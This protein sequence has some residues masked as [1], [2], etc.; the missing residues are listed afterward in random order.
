MSQMLLTFLSYQGLLYSL[1]TPKTVALVLLNLGQ[2][3]R[4]HLS[5]HS[6]VLLSMMGCLLWCCVKITTLA[7]QCSGVFEKHPAK[8]PNAGQELVKLSS[9]S[10]QWAY[11]EN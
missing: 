10:C 4:K 8:G 5:K 3:Q 9:F 7:R 11:L 1:V 6:S 2:L